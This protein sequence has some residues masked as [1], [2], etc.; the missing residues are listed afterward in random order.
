MI[1]MGLEFVPYGLQIGLLDVLSAEI[2]SI[3]RVFLQTIT[4]CSTVKL[5]NKL[6]GHR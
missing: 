5:L 4:Y 2:Q 1:E 3:Q 6:L